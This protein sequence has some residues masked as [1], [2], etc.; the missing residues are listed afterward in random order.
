ME[1]AV[2]TLVRCERCGCDVSTRRKAAHDE[3]CQGRRDVEP[4]SAWPVDDA[5]QA[6]RM[7]TLLMKLNELTDEVNRLRRRV[8]ELE[9]E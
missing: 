6:D 8:R 2:L 9:G 7:A 4:I 5:G 3:R 1:F